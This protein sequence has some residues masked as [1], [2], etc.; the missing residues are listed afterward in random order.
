[1][2]H[3]IIETYHMHEMVYLFK[4]NHVSTSLNLHSRYFAHDSMTIATTPFIILYYILVYHSN[5]VS[6]EIIEMFNFNM[7]DVNT[8]VLNLTF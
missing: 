3:Q 7:D 2:L 1:M 5:Y 8:H 4:C 6:M